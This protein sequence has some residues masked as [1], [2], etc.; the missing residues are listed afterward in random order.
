MRIRFVD[1]TR[2]EF[3]DAIS[4]YNKQQPKLGQRF[5]VEVEQ[6]ILWLAEHVEACKLRPGGYRR[7]NLRVFP[8]YIPY[9]VRG[10]VSGFLPLLTEGGSQNTGFKEQRSPTTF[11]LMRRENSTTPWLS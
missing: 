10:S 3:L 4:Y 6:S 9:V 1:E 7:L 5:K 11:R 8:Y 2:L